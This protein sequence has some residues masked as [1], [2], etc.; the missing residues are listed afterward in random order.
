MWPRISLL[1]TILVLLSACHDSNIAAAY[2]ASEKPALS[3]RTAL[4]NNQNI[5][6]YYSATGYTTIAR[7]IEISTSQS[8]TINELLVDEGDVIKA[9]ALLIVID[10]SELL[11]TI[12]QATSAIKSAKINLKDQR[13]DFNTSKRL[14]QTKFISA[15]QLRKAQVQ[16]DLANAQL[17]Q[18]NSE[19]KR[20]QVRKPYYRITTPI[21]ARVVQRWVSQGDLA[22]VGKPLL[23]LEAI[24][25]LEFETALPAQWIDQIHVGDSY[26]LR[27]HGTNKPAMATVSHIVHSSNRVTQT[28]Q[29]KL[30]L[31]DS[32]NL[33][34]GL[35]GQIDFII[36]NEKQLVVPE[37]SLIKKA[38]VM[39]V[40]RLNENNRVRFTPVKTERSWQ[41]Q[42]VI[43]SGLE[44]DEFIVLKPPSSLRDG[45]RMEV[46]AE[47][48]R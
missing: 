14:R 15:E 31:P 30:S 10:E 36:G 32:D 44:K 23:Q 47:R 4:V 11:A 48:N 25:G 6:R 5:P 7:T 21:A 29:I 26:Q 27:L 43:L 12:K 37:S 1:L 9:G 38:G 19:L 22:V 3:L 8:G 39:G 42:R 46:A 17:A 24:K 16:L 13:Q 20:Q 28:S 35:S 2:D 40:F 33:I 41:Q 18:A 45:T 34:A